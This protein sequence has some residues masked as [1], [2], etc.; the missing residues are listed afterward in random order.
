[1]GKAKHTDIQYRFEKNLIAN[2][3][4]KKN[5]IANRTNKLVNVN[6]ENNI[7]GLFTNP[8]DRILFSKL[9]NQLSINIV[10]ARVYGGIEI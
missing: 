2:N 10:P 8:L 4:F 5:L 3:R 6:T 7:A 9:R 1:M